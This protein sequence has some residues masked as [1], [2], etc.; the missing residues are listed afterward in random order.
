MLPESAYSYAHLLN[1][2]ERDAVAVESPPVGNMLRK[3]IDDARMEQG[4][5]QRS[6]AAAAG[7]NQQTVN[8]YL[9][10]EN[11]LTTEHAD[12]L[13]TVLGLCITSQKKKRKK[14]K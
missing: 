3:A 9:K 13:L 8:R 11:D 1:D 5:S 7:M 10:G 14:H 4:Y 2:D 12:K 6:L